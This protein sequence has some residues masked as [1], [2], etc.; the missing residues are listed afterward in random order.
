MIVNCKYYEL[1]EKKD[2]QDG[3]FIPAYQKLLYICTEE[4]HLRFITIDDSEVERIFWAKED[5]VRFIESKDEEWSKE[6]I[7]EFDNKINGN[8]IIN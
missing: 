3:H 5:E 2:M 1:K 8:W 7:N 4:N 6:K